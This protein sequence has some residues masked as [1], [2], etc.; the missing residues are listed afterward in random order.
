MLGGISLI[1]ALYSLQTLPVNYAGL[2]LILLGVILFIAELNVMTYGLLSVG[3]ATSLF[4]GSVMLIDSDDPAM[5][6]SRMVL[7]PTLGFSILVAGGIIYL[8]L[9]SRETKTVSGIE[10]MIGQKAQVK[11]ELNPAGSVL[12][13]GEVWNAHCDDR[14]GAGETVVVESVDG[15]K[16]KVKKNQEGE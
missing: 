15:L 6:I 7:Y 10:A 13:R 16:A 14:I 1:L 3:G 11:T 5:R 9:K 8:A 4:L 2:L 12:L